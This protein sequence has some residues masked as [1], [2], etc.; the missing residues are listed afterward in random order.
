MEAIKLIECPRDA[1]QG[2]QTPIGT[3]MKIAYYQM[4]LRVGYHT[5]DCGSFVNPKAIPQMADTAAVIKGL[6]IS[7][8]QTKLLTI[9]AN[10]R[11]AEE[12]VK[13]DKIH[14]LGYPF[15]VSENF[16]V[17]NTGKTIAESLTVLKH[18]NELTLRHKKEL[19]V[20]LSMGFGNPYGDP[21]STSI[22]KDWIAELADLGI[23]IISLSDTVGSATE[24][25]DLLFTAL[26]KAT[27]IG[28]WSAFS[29][30]SRPMVCQSKCCIF[31]RCKRFDGTVKG[32]GGCP[33]AHDEI[34]GNIPMEKLISYFT[35]HQLLPANLNNLAFESAYNFSHKI[36][37]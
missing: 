5:L 6:D 1:I 10:L 24:D 13:F 35:T 30:P 9:V 29:F 22:I 33:M 3:T 27:Q 7:D 19:V 17:R 8:T 31:G 26:I 15:S 37:I 16:Q 36:F 4:L 14:Y 28:I 34:I 12:A 25:I 11:G 18:I 21:W 20:Y 32:R 2:Y 23:K